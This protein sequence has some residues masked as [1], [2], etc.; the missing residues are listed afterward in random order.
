MPN[1]LCNSSFDFVA[2]CDI[3]V[4]EQAADGFGDGAAGAL[5]AF[6][7][8]NAGALAAVLVVPNQN[9]L[10]HRHGLVAGDV[11]V[12]RTQEMGGTAADQPLVG[13]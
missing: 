10:A 8:H 1:R 4:G 7:H 3:D 5:V 11:D 6:G 2:H 12:H 9:R 13:R